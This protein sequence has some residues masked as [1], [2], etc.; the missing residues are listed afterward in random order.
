M[1]GK[2]N[3]ERKETFIAART[4]TKLYLEFK[5]ACVNEN[6]T[7]QATLINLIRGWVEERRKT[8]ESE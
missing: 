2:V 4:P 5:K 1:A 7:I 3:L 6:V 8:D